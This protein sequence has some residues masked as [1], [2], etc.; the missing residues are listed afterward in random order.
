MGRQLIEQS[1]FGVCCPHT[2]SVEQ[3]KGLEISRGFSLFY[4]V[5]KLPDRSLVGFGG[6]LLSAGVEK[7]S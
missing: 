3:G 7:Q 1:R 5:L 4:S 6:R 2:R